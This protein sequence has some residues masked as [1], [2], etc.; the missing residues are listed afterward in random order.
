MGVVGQSK[1]QFTCWN[2]EIPVREKTSY[3]VVVIGIGTCNARSFTLQSLVH[4][5]EKELIHRPGNGRVIVGLTVGG[6]FCCL[7]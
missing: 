1:Y 4:V 6:I 5:E 3:G 7:V 2:R